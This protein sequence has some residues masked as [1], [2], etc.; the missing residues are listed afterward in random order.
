MFAI[1]FKFG[2]K[3]TDKYKELIAKYVK[4]FGDGLW[5]HCCII[6]TRCDMDSEK[7]KKRVEKGLETTIN[8]IRED[9]KKVSN[10]KCCDIPIYTFG[11]EN[12]EE[13]TFDLCS[14]LMNENNTFLPAKLPSNE[15]R[16]IEAVRRT[17]ELDVDNKD[18]FKS[19]QV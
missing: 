16:R 9:L 12:F 4:F 6:I 10:G 17:G 13:S 2:G 5:R 18:L 14:A 3:L 15:S 11:D 7:R 19:V 8:Q 1:F